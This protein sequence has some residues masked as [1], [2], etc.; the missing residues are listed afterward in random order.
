MRR[1]NTV[2]ISNASSRF[3]SLLCNNKTANTKYS[4]LILICT[5]RMICAVTDAGMQARSHEEP[6]GSNLSEYVTPSQ[7]NNKSPFP[8]YPGWLRVVALAIDNII[9]PRPY[10]FHSGPTS[11]HTTRP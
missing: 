4:K 10:L 9:W 2:Q 1:P 8:K 7:Q 11:G 5:S 6:W 3:M